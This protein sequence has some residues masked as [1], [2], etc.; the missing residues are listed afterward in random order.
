[1]QPSSEM[2][3]N[4]RSHHQFYFNIHSTR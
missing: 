3:R 1:M 4:S 2:F